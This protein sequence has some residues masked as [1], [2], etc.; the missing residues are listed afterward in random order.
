MGKDSSADQMNTQI[1]SSL[2]NIQNCQIFLRL[3]FRMAISKPNISHTAL[4][5]AA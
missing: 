3:I 1:L 2:K 5:T 4:D